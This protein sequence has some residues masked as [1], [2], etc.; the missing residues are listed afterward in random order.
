MAFQE[1]MS[2]TAVQRSVKD[3]EAAGLNPALAYDRS[4]STPSGVSATVGNVVSPGIASARAA[5]QQRLDMEIA[6]AQSQKDLEVKEKSIQEANARMDVAHQQANALESTVRLNTQAFLFNQLQQPFDLRLRAANAL[7]SELTV[8]GAQNEARL[9][10][11]LGP[12]RPALGDLLH[13]AK[14]ASGLLD[15]GDRVGS[16]LNRR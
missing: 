9:D 14:A 13:G 7:L 6:S 10:R 4:A 2:N 3:Y 16:I 1:R 8:P 12:M 11:M 15:V 5:A